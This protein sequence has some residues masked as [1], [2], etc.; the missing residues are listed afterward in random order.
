MK[1]KQ[2]WEPSKVVYSKDN[3][4]ASKDS[5]EVNVTSR[6]GTNVI[7]CNPPSAPNH[8]EHE[9]H[10]EKHRKLRDLRVL[11]GEFMRFW[12]LLGEKRGH[13]RTTGCTQCHRGL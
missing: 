8:E 13:P 7:G 2:S 11:W 6:L 12:P 1:N 3:L 9:E 4:V 5:N 10:E